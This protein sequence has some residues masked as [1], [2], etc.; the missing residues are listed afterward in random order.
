MN[1]RTKMII[2]TIFAL[3]RFLQV[4]SNAIK[5]YSELKLGPWDLDIIIIV[6]LPPSY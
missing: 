5:C 3:L 2:F 4:D 6:V 1:R